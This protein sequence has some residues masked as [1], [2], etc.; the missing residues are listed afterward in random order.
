[1]FK[2][3]NSLPVDRPMHYDNNRYIACKKGNVLC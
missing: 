1:M 3:K 2:G